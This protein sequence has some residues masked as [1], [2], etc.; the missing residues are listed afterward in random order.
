MLNTYAD[1]VRFV[2]SLTK[3]TREAFEEKYGINKNTIKSW[4][5][6]VNTLTEKSAKALSDA[7]N[8]EGFTCSPQWLIFGQ[9]SEPRLISE[10]DDAL[11]ESDLDQQSKIIYEADY[12]KKNNPNSIICMITDNSMDPDFRAGDYVGG[13][14]FNVSTDLSRLIGTACIVNTHDEL[15]KVRKIILAKND[16]I[17]LCPNNTQYEADVI[18]VEDI[19]AIASIIWHRIAFTRSL[20]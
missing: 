9:G 3:L 18:K 12:F 11:L 20:I 1:R 8:E 13:I 15:I 10:N 19:P 7:I 14:F 5:L 6:G 4:E 16:Q 17:V 2:R